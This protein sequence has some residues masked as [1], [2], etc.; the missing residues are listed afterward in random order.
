VAEA[1]VGQDRDQ[2]SGMETVAGMHS[3]AIDVGDGEG[4]RV[5][6]PFPAKHGDEAVEFDHSRGTGTSLDSVVDDEAGAAVVGA[7]AVGALAEQPLASRA[8]ARARG[9]RRH[10]RRY[11]RLIGDP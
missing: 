11:S 7:V 4:S 2:E 1:L 5:A 9:E 6:R 3:A 8:R 10:C